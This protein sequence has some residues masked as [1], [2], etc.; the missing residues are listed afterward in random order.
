MN[1]EKM[2]CCL[3]QYFFTWFHMFCTPLCFVDIQVESSFVEGIKMAAGFSGVRHYVKQLIFM[4]KVTSKFRFSV[5]LGGG[6]GFIK[7]VPGT[8][9]IPKLIYE[10][11][12]IFENV[13]L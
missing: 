4:Y 13:Y 2:Y 6:D 1:S 5:W 10:W 3:H 9:S 11:L 8:F 12:L 7:N